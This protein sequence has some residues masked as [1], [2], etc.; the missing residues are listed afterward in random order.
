MVHGRETLPTRG[1]SRP[2]SSSQEGQWRGPTGPASLAASLPSACP[3]GIP[4]I[5]ETCVIKSQQQVQ[6]DRMCGPGKGQEAAIPSD[7]GTGHGWL[8]GPSTGLR[9]E[10]E[11][12]ELSLRWLCPEWRSVICSFLTLFSHEPSSPRL[13]P[14]QGSGGRRLGS[15][16]L[17]RMVHSGR[18]KLTRSGA[19]MP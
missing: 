4:G 2:W 1:A 12:S 17:G 18:V 15:E 5:W 16:P 8:L 3:E 9:A 10:E 14:Q 19:R 6:M 7:C 11:D 13:V